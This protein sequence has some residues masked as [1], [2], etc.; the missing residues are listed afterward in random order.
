MDEDRPRSLVRTVFGVGREWVI[1]N[2]VHRVAGLTIGQTA[3]TRETLGLV[4]FASYELGRWW[5]DDGLWKR[6]PFQSYGRD[7]RGLNGLSDCCLPTCVR[8]WLIFGKIRM[9]NLPFFDPLGVESVYGIAP[10]LEVRW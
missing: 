4:A 6:N 10:D 7:F 2:Q 1:G 5:E 3:T 8:R 9:V